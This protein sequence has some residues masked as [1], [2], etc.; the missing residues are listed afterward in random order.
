MYEPQDT[1]VHR[2][3][4]SLY[5][6]ILAYRPIANKRTGY[7]APDRAARSIAMS[8]SVFLSVCLCLSVRDHISAT[9]RP[10]FSKFFVHV[11]YGRGS[12]LL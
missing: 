10:I 12:V 1:E 2:H 8:M 7:S 3:T 6:P 11:T 9:A 5:R 4:Y